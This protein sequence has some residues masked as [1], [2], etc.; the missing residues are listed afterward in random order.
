MAACS[1]SAA[2]PRNP[3]SR[4][5]CCPG[6][7]YRGSLARVGPEWFPASRHCGPLR[8]SRGKREGGNCQWSWP[9]HQRHRSAPQDLTHSRS[10]LA[11]LLTLRILQ[12]MQENSCDHVVTFTVTAVTVASARTFKLGLGPPSRTLSTIGVCRVC[13]CKQP[14]SS[15]L[16]AYPPSPPPR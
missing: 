5:S 7:L 6:G 1:I 14:W 9:P 2:H 4:I 10:C 8:T 3:P 16:R 13:I 12:G 11:H 15:P